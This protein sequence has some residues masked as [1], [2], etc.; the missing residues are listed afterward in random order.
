MSEGKSQ[1]RKSCPFHFA[2][3]AK[4]AASQLVS[5][6]NIESKK[7]SKEM[8][9]INTLLK[10]RV[11]NYQIG[12]I[13]FDMLDYNEIA[14]KSKKHKSAYPGKYE[15]IIP[16]DPNKNATFIYEQLSNNISYNVQT[17]LV[18]HKPYYEETKSHVLS[19]RRVM[20]EVQ[21]SNDS[22]KDL[23]LNEVNSFFE[24]Q[25]MQ[26]RPETADPI[27]LFNEIIQSRPDIVQQI[28]KIQS[29]L[30]TVLQELL[31]EDQQ[32]QHE[33]LAYSEIGYVVDGKVQPNSRFMKVLTNNYG[34]F[35]HKYRNKAADEILHCASLDAESE[36]LFIQ[37]LFLFEQDN[38][39][40]S[41]K[42]VD[43][44]ACP[45]IKTIGPMVRHLCPV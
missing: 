12:N 13:S 27:I 14:A 15:D 39:K 10:D 18:K 29:Q 40:Y 45:A 9:H 36:Q 43:S 19:S 31:N 21:N 41:L 2:D 28:L 8:V 22:F 42:D 37:R 3:T 4:I 7:A 44:R 33:S 1:I 24:Y 20:R 25:S 5:Y 35:F 23:D 34:Q 38:E 6:D 26:E 17:L 32:L 30:C 16:I 11:L